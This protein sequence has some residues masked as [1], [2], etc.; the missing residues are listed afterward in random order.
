[1]MNK[2]IFLNRILHN[3]IHYFILDCDN[4]YNF[5]VEDFLNKYS[6]H[7]KKV[8]THFEKDINVSLHKFIYLFFCDF[9]KLNLPFILHSDEYVETYKKIFRYL[10]LKYILEA[11]LII[12][13]EKVEK[14]RAISPKNFMPAISFKTYAEFKFF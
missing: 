4:K 2:H 7:N 11:S 10:K 14:I 13:N 8:S 12:M 5:V 9:N 6:L 1:M 3:N